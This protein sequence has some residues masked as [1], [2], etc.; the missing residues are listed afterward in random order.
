MFCHWH[1][2]PWLLQEPPEGWPVSTIKANPL[3]IDDSHFSLFQYTL[4]IFGSLIFSSTCKVTIFSCFP[5]Q[6]QPNLLVHNNITN[7]TLV[8]RELLSG[9]VYKEGHTH[10]GHD[11]V[12]FENQQKVEGTIMTLYFDTIVLLL[13]MFFVPR[14]ISKFLGFHKHFGERRAF[15]RLIQLRFFRCESISMIGHGYKPL[16]LQWNLYGTPILVEIPKC[17]QIMK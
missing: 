5:T 15:I 10:L 12:W 13:Y 8:L 1:L 4:G 11:E 17:S 7:R 3:M 2:H 16:P 6:T 14:D 9:L